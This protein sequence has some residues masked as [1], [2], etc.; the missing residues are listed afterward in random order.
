VKW[1]FVATFGLASP[2]SG[3]IRGKTRSLFFFLILPRSLPSSR[4]LFFNFLFFFHRFPLRVPPGP[5]TNLFIFNIIRIAA[6]IYLLALLLLPF[7]LF[8]YYISVNHDILIFSILS[9]FLDIRTERSLVCLNL[10]R[11]RSLFFKKNLSCYINY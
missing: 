1:A 9:R 7:I 2:V 5:N 6:F 8:Y 3:K 4:P 11:R 10:F